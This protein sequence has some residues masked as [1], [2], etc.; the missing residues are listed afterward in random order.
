VK[1]AGRNTTETLRDRKEKEAM[2]SFS[3]NDRRRSVKAKKKG[4]H[5]SIVSGWEKLK[6]HTERGF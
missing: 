2:A 3:L 6:M 1:R 5:K 4:L